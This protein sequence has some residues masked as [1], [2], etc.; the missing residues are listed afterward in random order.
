MDVLKAQGERRLE[1]EARP[2]E[3]LNRRRHKLIGQAKHAVAPL[4]GMKPENMGFVTNATGGINAVLRSLSYGFKAGDELITTNHVYNAVRKAMQYTARETG[5]T[6]IEV[7]VPMPLTSPERVVE[8]IERAITKRTRLVVVD[9]ISSPTAVIFPMKEI[10]EMCAA[11]GVDVLVDG[12]HAPGMVELN[13]EEL[14][15]LGAT[16]YAANLHKWICAPPGAA[17]LWVRPDKQKRIHPTT[18]SHFLDE[19]FVNEFNWQGTRDIT[20]WLC[21][22]D[23][24]AY[25]EKYGLNRVMKHNR[26]MAVWVQEMLCQKWNV[27]PGSPRDGSMLGSMATVEL[28]AQEKVRKKFNECAALMAVLYDRYRIEV[29]VLD[30]GGRWRV[31]PCCQIYNVAEHYERLADAVLKVADDSD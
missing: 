6:Y 5:S 17:F 10:L 1:F 15:E 8:A 14:G 28:P 19:S 30:W 9:H 4:L 3:W 23:S 27:Q 26:Q 2:I 22:Q 24:I 11:R 29:P 12:A 18:I 16:Y 21:V 13:V 20:P 31:R 25:L 7:N